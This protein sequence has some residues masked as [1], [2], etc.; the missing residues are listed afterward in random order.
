MALT[1]Y[2]NSRFVTA[3]EVGTRVSSTLAVAGDSA[4][5]QPSRRFAILFSRLCII[6]FGPSFH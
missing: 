2:A 6:V 1:M 4:R 5:D 3:F